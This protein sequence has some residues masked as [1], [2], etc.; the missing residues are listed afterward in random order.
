MPL[1]QSER[2]LVLFH[3]LFITHSCVISIVLDDLGF[4]ATSEW[5]ALLCNC[6]SNSGNVQTLRANAYIRDDMI[7][8]LIEACTSTAIKELSFA[9]VGGENMHVLTGA[10]MQQKECLKTL[11]MDEMCTS[12]HV[13]LFLNDVQQYTWLANIAL[14]VATFAVK[15]IS[16]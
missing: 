8:D 10:I 6:I 11:R 13:M 3:K 16:Y 15:P 12:K 7:C 2:A 9:R 4:F 1:Y 5:F 14:D